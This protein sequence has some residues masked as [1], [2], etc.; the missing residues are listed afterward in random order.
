MAITAKRYMVNQ[1]AR[2][3]DALLRRLGGR[4]GKPA[5]ELKP[6]KGARWAIKGS[7][8]FQHR[9]LLAYGL[10]SPQVSN[11]SLEILFR[12]PGIGLI[13]HDG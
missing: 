6:N 2:S 4:I 7:P 3:L 13:G 1:V 12:H 9:S 5:K 8:P 10:E 11:Q